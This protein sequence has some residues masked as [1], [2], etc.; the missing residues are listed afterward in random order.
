RK[1]VGAAGRLAPPVPPATYVPAPAGAD[2][3]WSARQRL[4]QLPQFLLLGAVE[5]ADARLQLVDALLLRLPVELGDDVL[6]LLAPLGRV[7]RQVLAGE[8]LQG[9]AILVVG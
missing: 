3:R 6:E 7:A 2:P 1:A 4:Q 8:F 9:G 5:L